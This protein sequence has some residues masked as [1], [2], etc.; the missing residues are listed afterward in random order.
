[1]KTTREANLMFYKGLW[2]FDEGK[3]QKVHKT[4][5]RVFLGDFTTQSTTPSSSYHI[6]VD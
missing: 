1:M 5:F 6:F 4:I 2:S 3:T